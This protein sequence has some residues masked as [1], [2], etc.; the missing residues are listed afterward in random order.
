MP[1]PVF[2]K[3]VGSTWAVRLNPKEA[4]ALYL[5]LEDWRSVAGSHYSD[6]VITQT[7]ASG[8]GVNTTVAMENDKATKKDITDY[9][10]W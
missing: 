7:G 1:K 2:P 5:W 9:M 4:Y 6:V 8:I 10:A 3:I